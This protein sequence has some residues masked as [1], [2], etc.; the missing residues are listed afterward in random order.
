MIFVSHAWLNEKPDE[1]VLSFVDFLRDNGYDAQCDV[2]LRQ[3]K[4]AIS[5]PE[6]MAT[7][8]ATSEKTILMLSENYKKK[9]DGFAGG[10]GEE[11]RYII[12]DFASNSDKYI[13]VSFDGI[14]DNIIPDFLKG[15]DVIDLKKDIMNGY[16]EL[17]S[18]L[19]SNAIYHFSEVA[20]HKTVP[21]PEAIPK[22][23][24]QNHSVA[25][26]YGVNI[27]EAKT[28]LTDIE[29]KGF[30]KGAYNELV[31][32]ISEI[33]AEMRARNP[34]VEITKESVN[35]NT[36]ILE[37]YR[38][39]KTQ[40]SIRIWIDNKLGEYC[41]FVGHV[42]FGQNAFSEMVDC[43]VIDGKPYLNPTMQMTALKEKFTSEMLVRYIWKKY[44]EPYYTRR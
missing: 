8:L 9:A 17:F 31:S 30:L 1:Q 41:I 38:D 29:K 12:G 11:Y 13:L 39:G 27:S 23:Q 43:K 6:M 20:L 33:A 28:E 15:R 34:S 40:D 36:A 32:A 3:R 5:F 42:S 4:T 26:K 22:F 21:E 35:A 14:T 44:F 25:A 7:S 18:K 16:K 10:V 24:E 37:I 19:S 2:M